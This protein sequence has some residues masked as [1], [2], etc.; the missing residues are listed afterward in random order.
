MGYSARTYACAEDYLADSANDLTACLISDIRMP[1]MSG[2]QLFQ[3]LQARGHCFPVIFITAC[4]RESSEQ[5]AQELGAAGYFRKPFSGHQLMS[6][7][8]A[9][10]S[11]RSDG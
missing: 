2:F 3:A 4:Q 9:V 5:K 7:V 11:A 1:G 6:R 10:L 8:Q